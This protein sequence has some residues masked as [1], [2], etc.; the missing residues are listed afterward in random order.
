MSTKTKVN[1]NRRRKARAK[2]QQQ[3]SQQN[4]EI[5]PSQTE[6]QK[7]AQHH[8]D[9]H[10]HDEHHHDEHHQ[11]NHPH[12][13]DAS[14]TKKKSEETTKD[15]EPVEH[16]DDDEPP[17]LEAVGSTDVD[18]EKQQGEKGGRKKPSRTEKKVEKRF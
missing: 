3:Q 2:Q 5:S 14:D 11:H 6:E 17:A 9:E 7:Q 18:A 13:H 12:T 4:K 10:H 8:H 1:K 15:L 16:K